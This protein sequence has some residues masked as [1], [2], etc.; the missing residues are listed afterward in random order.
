MI[1]GDE[2]SCAGS[3]V[4]HKKRKPHRIPEWMQWDIPNRP[5][6]SLFGKLGTSIIKNIFPFKATNPNRRLQGK[7]W[8]LVL[9][10]LFFLPLG[11]CHIPVEGCELTSDVLREHCKLRM[12]KCIFYYN[13][14]DW[15]LKINN[16]SWNFRKLVHWVCFVLKLSS[17]TLRIIFCNL[18][19]EN[20][21]KVFLCFLAS[22][23]A[24]LVPKSMFKKGSNLFSLSVWFLW[25][26]YF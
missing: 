16:K 9:A 6:G 14:F 23:N 13:P 4:T 10:E 11:K 20:R 1:P 24:I 21:M 26:Q 18:C 7:P 25:E 17:Y 19:T 15:H 12:E 22:L 5:G 8:W 3:A 2:N